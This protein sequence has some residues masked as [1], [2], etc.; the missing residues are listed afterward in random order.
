MENWKPIASFEE[1]YEVS[2]LGNVRSIIK[3]P[4]T[5]VGKILKAKLRCGY[6]RFG[7]TTL[8]GR[9]KWVTA[10]RLVAEHFIP[11]P[12]N[13]PEVNHI[14][15]R[16]K[17]HDSVTNLE[18]DTSSGNTQKAYDTSL[19]RLGEKRHNSKLKESDIPAIRAYLADGRSLSQI[20]RWYGVCA[21]T[22]SQI[23][24]G[25]AWKRVK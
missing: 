1:I 19:N 12:S 10:S 14:D 4:N 7:L 18:W 2:D 16:Q 9:V 24:A 8:D 3:R 22:I 13:L 23:K 5:Y 6:R 15:G 11:N 25:K 21:M 17:Q 20:G